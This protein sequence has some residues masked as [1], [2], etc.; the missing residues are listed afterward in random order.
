M[1]S[2]NYENKIFLTGNPF[3]LQLGKKGCRFAVLSGFRG[4]R[5]AEWCAVP[6]NQSVYTGK[7]SASLPCRH[8]AE[9]FCEYHEDEA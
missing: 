9:I 3:T 1:V 7:Q 5:G 8:Y 6:C 4:L 2:F